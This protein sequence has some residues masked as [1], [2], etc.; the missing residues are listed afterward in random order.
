MADTPGPVRILSL[1]EED[2]SHVLDEDALSTLLLDPR[3]AD[4]KVSFFIN[5][6][7]HF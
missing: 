6:F 1:N 2:H 4:K 5:V 3:Y 7:D